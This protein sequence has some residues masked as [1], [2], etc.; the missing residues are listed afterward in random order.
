MA[1]ELQNGGGADNGG[2][3]AV[4]FSAVKP[5]LFVEDGKANDAV[6][7]YKAAFGAEEVSRSV[8]PKRKADQELPLVLSAELHLGSYSFLV[9][10]LAH[11][12]STPVKTSGTGF[13]ICLETDDVEAAVSKAVSAGAVS[14]GEVA[15]GDGACC[16]GRVGKVKDP[17]GFVWMICSPAENCADVEARAMP[18]AI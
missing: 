13:V 15:E 18:V 5:Q 4:V 6:Q 14:E 10:D 1:L 17:Y 16:G 2:S 7:F 12:S 8:H 11:D 3:K 9:S